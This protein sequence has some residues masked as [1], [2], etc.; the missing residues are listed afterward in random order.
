MEIRISDCIMCKVQPLLAKKTHNKNDCDF[1][2]LA[3]S[4]QYP[5][6]SP[7]SVQNFIAFLCRGKKKTLF[8]ISSIV[9]AH[10]YSCNSSKMFLQK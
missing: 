4:N 3:R 9:G 6:D 1:D 2:I 5:R 10:N 8:R 7:P